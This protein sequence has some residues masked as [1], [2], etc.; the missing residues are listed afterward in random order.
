LRQAILDANGMGGGMIQFTIP[1][2][3]VHTIRPLT[4]L[5]TITQ[6]VTIDGYTQPGASANTNSPT[7]GLNTVLTIELSG[8]MAPPNSNFSGLII[9]ADNCTVRGLVI[10]SFQHDAIDVLSNGNVIAGNFIGTNTA[11]T[12]ALPNGASGQGGVIFVGSLSNNTVGGPTPATRNLISGNIGAGVNLATGTGDTVQGNLIGTDVTGT[13]AL[14][15]T[16]RGVFVNGSSNIVGGTTVAAR[17]I[18]SANSRGVDLFGG[19][20]N[21]V[22]GNFIG[23]DVTGTVAL[24]NPNT[25]VNVN[26]TANNVIGGLT[27]TPGTPPGNLISGGGINNGSPGVWLYAGSSGNLVQGNIIGADITGTQPLGN[28]RGIEIEGHDNTIG[29]M[30]AGAA[31]IIAFNGGSTPVCNAARQSRNLGA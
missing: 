28:E 9:N 1:G 2:T 22:Q 19:T 7:M 4:A 8:A 29:G 24:G 16:D 21:T 25:G 10:N 14:G 3:G 27:A 11:G 23:T 5:P 12:A 13:L 6:S 20:N 17:N 31:N 30:A 18:I 15:N 26:G